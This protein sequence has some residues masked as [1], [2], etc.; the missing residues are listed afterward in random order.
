MVVF[1]VAP[2]QRTEAERQVPQ[3]G[4]VQHRLAFG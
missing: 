3:R 4:V 2:E 1:Q